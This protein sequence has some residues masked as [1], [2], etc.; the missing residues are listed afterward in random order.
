M[1]DKK[2]SETKKAAQRKAEEEDR[3]LSVNDL[4]EPG[5]SGLVEIP[6]DAEPDLE[7]EEEDE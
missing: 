7:L 3:A 6:E 2:Y 5:S 1:A 4:G